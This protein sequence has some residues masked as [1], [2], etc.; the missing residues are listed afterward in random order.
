M[1]ARSMAALLKLRALIVCDA[2]MH[3]L[4]EPRTIV[5]AVAGIEE[6]RERRRI[7]QSL[8]VILTDMLIAE[9]AGFQ[10]EPA[11]IDL[12]DALDVIEIR[13]GSNRRD[14][15]RRLPNHTATFPRRA[16]GGRSSG[17]ADRP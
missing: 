14:N 15:Q 6:K 1:S 5:A 17:S 10:T 16:D 3:A 11:R 2:E 9:A 8:E 7:L 12:L 4:L 13:S